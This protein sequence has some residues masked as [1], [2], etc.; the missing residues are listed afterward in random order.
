MRQY[1]R[2]VTDLTQAI[3]IKPTPRLYYVRGLALARQGKY[4]PAIEDY[5]RALRLKPDLA[6]VYSYRSEAYRKLGRHGL[7]KRDDERATRMYAKMPPAPIRLPQGAPL[8]RVITPPARPAQAPPPLKIAA[9]PPPGPPAPAASTPPPE[10][11]PPPKPPAKPTTTPAVAPPPAKTPSLFHVPKSGPKSRPKS[12]V[13]GQIPQALVVAERGRLA[14]KRGD[15]RPAIGLYTHALGMKGLGRQSRAVVLALRG[16]AFD[17]LKQGRRAI[18][19]YSRAIAIT[20]RAVFYVYRAGAWRA[21]GRPRRA[22]DDFNSAVRLKSND[23][24]LYLARGELYYSL[25]RYR[26]ATLDF[27][28]AIRLEPRNRWPTICAASP[29]AK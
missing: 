8:P 6:V 14:A 26:R 4:R 20:P 28:R 2:A 21:M 29:A 7:A 27:D 10:P 17:S 19:D 24:R 18:A 15:H 1:Q 13:K 25:R 12:P 11:T 16:R 5:N 9:K 3:G 23:A 22:V